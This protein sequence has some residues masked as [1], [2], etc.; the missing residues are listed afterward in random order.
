MRE[1]L[2]TGSGA[3]RAG[4]ALSGPIFS[5]PV[6]RRRSG[7]Q[8]QVFAFKWSFVHRGARDLVNPSGWRM[9]QKSN[10]TRCVTVRLQ[11]AND[12]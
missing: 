9:E 2:F 5:G 1:E 10:A 7:E 4:S 3:R 6:N 12:R 8:P 11:V